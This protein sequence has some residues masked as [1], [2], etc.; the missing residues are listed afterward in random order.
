MS[1]N[2]PTRGWAVRARP[3]SLQSNPIRG[4]LR[5]HEEKKMLSKALV[6]GVLLALTCLISTPPAKA[7]APAQESILQ[8]IARTK[9][10]HA[11]YIPYPPFAIVDPATKK[12]SGYFIEMMDAIVAE[13]GQGIKI[14]Y[15]ETTWGTMVVG[16]QSGKFDVVVSGILSTIPRAMQVTFTRPVMLLGLSAVARADDNR[17]KTEADLRKP[18]LT[19]AVTAGEVGH[20]YAQKFLPDAKLIVLDTPDITRPMLEVLSKRADIGIADSISVANFVQAHKGVATNVFAERPLLRWGTG[21]L[22]PRDL[23]W[24]DFLDQSIN[25]LEYTNVLDRL[26]AKY[27]KG[28]TEWV[29][30]K[31]NY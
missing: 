15:E 23:Q 18:G 20:S 25:F 30:M 12:L 7:Q 27:K 24:K 19:I 16:A 14:E 1:A 31:K 5:R 29:T 9:V 10:I 28:S 21:L 17:F 22:L 13:M 2:A 26:E 4:E 3:L 11:G 8:K 6:A